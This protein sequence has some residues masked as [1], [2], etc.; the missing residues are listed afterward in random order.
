MAIARIARTRTHQFGFMFAAVALLAGVLVAP[1]GAAT[2]T[3]VVTL[4]GTPVTFFAQPVATSLTGFSNTSG[5]ATAADF[6]VEIVVVDASLASAGWHLQTTAP[7]FTGAV[8]ATKTL[9]SVTTKAGYATGV[10]A[11][12]TGAPAVTACTAP[13]CDTAVADTETGGTTISPTTATTFAGAATNHGQ[14]ITPFTKTFTVAIPSTASAQA[15]QSTFT[16][17]IVS[18]P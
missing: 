1:V 10:T 16:M 8:D 15:Y 6:S 5:R 13:V 11:A 9:G 12:V 3:N 14:G 18:G 17:S 2:V 7:T 4:N